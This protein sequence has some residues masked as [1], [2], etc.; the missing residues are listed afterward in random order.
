[1]TTVASNAPTYRGRFAPTPTGP[2]H[3]GSLLVAFGSWLLARR[4]GGAW[5]VRIEDS[6]PRGG[7]PKRGRN[8]RPLECAGKKPDT[9]H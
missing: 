1:M 8:R 3:L 5:L 6:D 2:L 7:T 9:L 4:A